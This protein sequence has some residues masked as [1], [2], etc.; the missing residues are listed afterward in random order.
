MTQSNTSTNPKDEVKD[1]QTDTPNDASKEST[2][3]SAD[4]T[5]DSSEHDPKDSDAVQQDNQQD[6]TQ[7][8]DALQLLDLEKTI[9]T[10]HQSIAMKQSELKKNKDM[11]KDTLENDAVYEEHNS[12][13]NEAKRVLKETKD[14]LMAVP[15]VMSTRED[16]KELSAEIRDLKKHLSETLMKYYDKAQ[17]NNITMDD[18]QT[19]VIRT[20]AKLVKQSS[21]YNP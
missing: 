11:I 15:S 1:S 7:G 19:Y 3:E 5:S 6:D 18:G 2:A 14:Q 12:T 10:Y 8:G 21:K 9:K 4:A 13:V 16:M 17:T 20:Q